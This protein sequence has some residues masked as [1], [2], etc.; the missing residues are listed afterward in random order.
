MSRAE[1]SPASA[2]PEPTLR[3]RLLR[4]AD[5]L[6]TLRQ[7]FRDR[8]VLEVDTPILSRVT[9]TDPLLDSFEVLTGEE[10]RYLLTSPEHALKRLLAAG[11]GPVYQLGKAFR[12][13]EFGARHNPE[14]TLLEWYR[15]GFSLEDLRDEVITLLSTVGFTGTPQRF[16]WRDL[17]Q[18]VCGFDPFRTSDEHLIQQ[19]LAVAG[20]GLSAEALDR[21]SALD[22]LMSHRVEPWL[23]RHA[24]AFVEDYPA[25]QAALAVI[26][27]D[28]EGDRVARRFELYLHGMEIANAYQEL[29][30]PQEQRSRFEADNHKRRSLGLAEVPVDERLLAVL[31]QVPPCA[32]IALGVDRLLLQCERRRPPEQRL[33]GLDR[34]A[35]VLPLAWDGV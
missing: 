31:A 1:P 3:E 5:F 34:L 24:I 35:G 6:A 27:T 21:D 10:R 14:F 29:I 23:A 30:D 20:G 2:G 8:D 28:A 11:S 17:F 26:D 22:L 12:R 19:A 18:T 32:G 7:F 33:D 16:R 25:S 9:A 13:G 15:P 4:R